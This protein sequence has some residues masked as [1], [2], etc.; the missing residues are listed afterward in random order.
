M[1]IWCVSAS[2]QIFK[3]T[4]KQQEDSPV[5]L[6]SSAKNMFTAFQICLRNV[7]ASFDVSGIELPQMPSGISCEHYFTDYIVFNDGVPYPDIISTKASAQVLCNTTQSIFIRFYVSEDADTGTYQLPINVNTSEGLFSATVSLTVYPVALP[8]PKDSDI[9]HEYFFEPML[10]YTHTDE[11]TKKL[12]PTEYPYRLYS[13]KF[14]SLMGDFAKKFKE[15]RVNCLHIPVL[16]LLCDSGSKRTDTAK[17]DLSYKLLDEFIEFFML[18]GSVKKLSIK[19]M[20]TSV[21]GETIS[22]ID[23]NGKM[24]SL[25]IFTPEADAWAEAIYGGIYAHFKEKGWLNMLQMRLE[26]EPHSSEYWKWA[27]EKCRTFMPDVICGEPIDTHSI[28]RELENECDQYIPRIEIYEEGKD[29]YLERQKAGDQVWCYSCCYPE[30][31]GWMNKFI[32]LPCLYSRL[33]AWACFSHGI[34][35]FL[36]WGSHYWN[37]KL[38]G[39][40]SDARFKGDGFIVYPHVENNSLLHSARGFATCDGFQDW[41]LLLML[42]KKHP[43]AANAISLRIAKAFTDLHATAADVDSA[44]TEIL[45]LLS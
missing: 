22:A 25:N 43:E 42:K 39:L 19:A 37:N 27:R 17:W 6:L 24:I 40:D 3:H 26:D 15:L 30:V 33:M 14:W 5:F 29:Y 10:L 2:A 44:R 1:D 8:E 4:R 31:S 45:T 9:Y 7:D 18:N 36:H 35:G 38:Y 20:I 21:S 41:E 13:E 11:I 12:M 28:S 23:E 16:K 32:D 34:E